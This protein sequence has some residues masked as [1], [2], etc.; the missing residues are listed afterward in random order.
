MNI[1]VHFPKPE[2][3]SPVFKIDSNDNAEEH[4]KM[5]IPKPVTSFE[6][7]FKD[8]PEILGECAKQGFS[9]PTPIQCQL[10]PCIMTGHDVVGI[11]QTGSGNYQ[12]ISTM[13]QFLFF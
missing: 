2:E 6:Q 7:A 8:Y 9:A 1:K 5:I 4:E 13:H 10:W 3:L 12:I 11:A